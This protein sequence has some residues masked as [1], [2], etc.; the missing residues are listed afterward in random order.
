MVRALVG[1]LL[2]A[3]LAAA[4]LWLQSSIWSATVDDYLTCRAVIQEFN[5]DIT[6]R[7]ELESSASLEIRCEVESKDGKGMKIIEIVAEGATV[8]AGDL[9]VRFDD[10]G[11]RND[12]TQQEIA[13]NT[14]TAAVT[15]ARNEVDSAELAKREYEHGT[16]LQEDQKADSEVYVAKENLERA[17]ANLTYKRRLAGKGFTTLT[18]VDAEFFAVA[19]FRRELAAAETKRNVLREY[20]KVKTLRKHDADI[21]TAKA[22]LVSEEAKLQ[23]EKDKLTKIDEQIAK[24]IVRAPRGGQVIYDHSQDRWGGDDRIIKEGSFVYERRVVIEMPDPTKMQVLAKIPESRID[25]LKIGMTA[26][27]EVEGLPGKKLNGVVTKVNSFPAEGNWYNS[28]VKQYETTV[29]IPQPPAGLR[30]GMTAQV[31]IRA[32]HLDSA[33]QVPLLAVAEINGCHY[34]L[35]RQPNGSLTPRAVRLGSSN[36]KHLVVNDGLAANDELVLDPRARLSKIEDLPAALVAQPAPTQ[37]PATS[38]AE[39]ATTQSKPAPDAMA[40]SEPS[41]PSG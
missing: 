30:P 41:G 19:K 15:Q 26:E 38:P 21:D 34:C 32:E 23:I 14:A 13:I 8:K 29:D 1:L 18:A 36:E 31:S 17:E 5:F 7:G 25:K 9:L 27:I 3:G 11:L 10:S 2:L 40:Q 39:T 20:T 4:G 33:L 22:K 24:C 35:C 12:R 16:F 28:S 6:E 37:A